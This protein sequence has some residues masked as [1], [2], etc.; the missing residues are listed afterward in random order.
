MKKE[1][2]DKELLA[3]IEKEKAELSKEETEIQERKV[4]LEDFVEKMGYLK[5]IQALVDW[6]NSKHAE[7]PKKH[8]TKFELSDDGG[9]EWVYTYT[10]TAKTG[11]W[12]V[13][14]E[15][16]FFVHYREIVE[17]FAAVRIYDGFNIFFK[18]EGLDIKPEDG[19]KVLKEKMI[20][21]V[22]EGM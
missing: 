20:A 9:D 13:K 17:R 21:I 16:I 4:F 2:L 8:P 12:G 6:V 19:I 22:K 18:D 10:L 14:K 1:D 5:D 11:I 15:I 7:N 3:T